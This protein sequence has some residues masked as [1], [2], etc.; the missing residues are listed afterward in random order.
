MEENYLDVT[1]NNLLIVSEVRAGVTVDTLP[2]GSPN[3]V[4][5]L[6]Q[7]VE[8]S[9]TYVAP[10]VRLP[11]R[12]K[13]GVEPHRVLTI[14]RRVGLPDGPTRCWSRVTWTAWPRGT[15][16]WRTTRTT[17]TRSCSRASCPVRLGPPWRRPPAFFVVLTCTATSWSSERS[18]EAFRDGLYVDTN[19]RMVVKVNYN[20]DDNSNGART[21]LMQPVAM[22][23]K[24]VAARRDLAGATAYESAPTFGRRA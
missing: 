19:T 16:A 15:R 12:S 21:W 10:V 5:A 11:C 24:Y 8:M 7:P 4:Q 9:D 18:T 22:V 23:R 20:R 14:R 6:Y 13:R 17:C 1:K 3:V 2:S